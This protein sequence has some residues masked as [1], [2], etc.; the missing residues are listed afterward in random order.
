M[1][2]LGFI[3]IPIAELPVSETF[4][5]KSSELGFSTLRQATDL[6]WGKLCRLEGFCYSWFDEL[7]VLLKQRG[8]LGL[9]EH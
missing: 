3:D 9:L 8:L 2:N 1:G 4:K 5:Q 6:G 7:V